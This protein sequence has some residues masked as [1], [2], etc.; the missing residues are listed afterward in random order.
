ML[1]LSQ[2]IVAEL[3]A[4]VRAAPWDA[5]EQANCDR[6]SQIV[7]ENSAPVLEALERQARE[8]F[9]R[10]FAE[11]SPEQMVQLSM[12]SGA[13]GRQMT[14]AQQ[15]LQDRCTTYQQRVMA[16]ESAA[17]GFRSLFSAQSLLDRW[18]RERVAGLGCSCPDFRPAGED[19]DHGCSALPICPGQQGGPRIPDLERGCRSIG[20][21]AWI[22]R[23]LPDF[24]RTLGF[25][26]EIEEV[27][28]VRASL[29]RTLPSAGCAQLPAPSAPP[30]T[31]AA[32]AP[33]PAAPAAIA[34][35]AACFA[36]P[37]P[38]SCQ[39]ALVR[40]DGLVVAAQSAGRDRCLGYA[41]T[42]RTLWALGADPRF[43]DLLISFPEAARL[44]NEARIAL[45]YLR[46][47][48]KGL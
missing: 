12:S 13:E 6:V 33:G 19:V 5:E 39:E 24:Y 21:A 47:D 46:M 27:R 28:D 40:G 11:L 25:P 1:L 41:L 4:P 26:P 48:C 34:A 29:D 23:Q 8:R 43:T 45:R 32:S 17:A 14:E 38:A 9:G 44:R 35:A 22:R 2:S 36:S 7:E 37:A 16:K 3:T 15:R 30:L 18:G 31:I 42:A 10:S 20:A